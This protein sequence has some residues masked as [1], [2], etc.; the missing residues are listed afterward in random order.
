VS[1]FWVFAVVVALVIGWFVLDRPVE[2]GE[3]VQ[4]TVA[5]IAPINIPSGP[6]QSKLVAKLS[7]GTVVELQIPRNDALTVG[8]PITLQRLKRRLSGIASYSFAM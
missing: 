7:D 8:A 5:N 6:P 2:P 3:T 4:A 1:N